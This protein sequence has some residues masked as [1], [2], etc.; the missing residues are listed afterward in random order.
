[1]DDD[2]DV[3][4][5]DLAVFCKDWLWEGWFWQEGGEISITGSSFGGGSFASYSTPL[6]EQPQQEK[7]SE[8]QYLEET[9]NTI[10]AVKELQSQFFSDEQAKQ[11]IIEQEGEEAWQ[12]TLD[13]L[14]DWLKELEDAL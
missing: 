10:E 14:D 9:K 8:E 7:F 1:M 6:M 11:L 3:D 2:N 4:I 5:Y 12:K 13:M